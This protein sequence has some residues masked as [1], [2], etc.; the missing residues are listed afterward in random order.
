[1]GYVPEEDT[2][3]ATSEVR[4][5]AQPKPAI[6][7]DFDRVLFDTDA[8]DSG[9]RQAMKDIGI[10]RAIWD[11]AIKEPDEDGVLRIDSLLANVAKRSRR[12]PKQIRAAFD[13]E[14]S[15][16]MWYLYADTREFLERFR[17]AAEVHL[18]S[19]GSQ[20]WQNQKIDAVGIRDFFT[21]VT[22]VEEPKS[23][24]KNLP[25]PSVSQ[26]LFLGS[27]SKEM[28]DVARR[29][30]WAKHVHINRAGEELPADFPFASYPD[31]RTAAPEI[32]S[33]VGLALVTP[34]VPPTA[35]PEPSPEASE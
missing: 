25:V 8:Y 12:Q 1:M 26:A 4:R 16:A 3:P 9:L 29:Y 15:E 18:L 28:L 31:L 17:A 22:V 19:F 14:T 20:E 13:R 27:N 35:Q 33:L 30:R 7:V 6:V 11:A 21:H 10:D 5:E 23:Q 34:E 2:K 32:A 24:A